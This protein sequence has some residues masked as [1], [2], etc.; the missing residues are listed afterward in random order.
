MCAR[1][2]TDRS[3]YFSERAFE[4]PSGDTT[5]IF[6]LYFFKGAHMQDPLL[7][8]AAGVLWPEDT[9]LLKDA[10]D[11]SWRS[12]AFAYDDDLSIDA[13]L[14]RKRIARSLLINRARGIKSGSELVTRA[15]AELQPVP[16]KWARMV[17]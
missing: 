7:G 17:S 5:L 4:S 13:T 3:S 8:A 16:A 9:A 1:L 6:G 10:F 15:L 12:L 2:R 14:I 11:E